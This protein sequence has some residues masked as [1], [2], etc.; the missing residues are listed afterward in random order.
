MTLMMT[1][2]NMK[3]KRKMTKKAKAQEVLK[4]LLKSKNFSE[5]SELR[6]ELNYLLDEIEQNKVRAYL[7][8]EAKTNLG[9]QI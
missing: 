9:V 6:D 4:K 1:L 3:V 2:M 8:R 7:N 5:I